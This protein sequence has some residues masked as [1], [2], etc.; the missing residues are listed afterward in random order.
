MRTPKTKHVTF[1]PVAKA[2][3]FLIKC[4]ALDTYD[5]EQMY[6]ILKDLLIYTFNLGRQEG[7][8]VQRANHEEFGK[9]SF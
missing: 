6:P 4:D 7:A 3:D 2:N 8:A 5:R 9:R 1:D